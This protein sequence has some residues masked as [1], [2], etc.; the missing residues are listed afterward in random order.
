M[1]AFGEAIT[2]EDCANIIEW[3]KVS[4]TKK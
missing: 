2:P 1:P 3:I 4:L